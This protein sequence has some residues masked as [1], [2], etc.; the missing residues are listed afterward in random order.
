[1]FFRVA[2]NKIRENPRYPRHPR[3][4]IVAKQQNSSALDNLVVCCIGFFLPRLYFDTLRRG[5][6]TKND[7]LP[8]CCGVFVF[9]CALLS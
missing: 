4:K 7:R 3:Q 1:M 2:K 6:D 8:D 9:F 5:R